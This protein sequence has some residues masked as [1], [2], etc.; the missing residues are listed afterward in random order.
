MVQPPVGYLHQDDLS[1]LTHSTWV[2]HRCPSV[3]SLGR[4]D[5]ASMAAEGLLKVFF[6]SFF[7]M[8]VCVCAC[9]YTHACTHIHICTH[10]HMHT[11]THIHTKEKPLAATGRAAPIL[12]SALVSGRYCSFHEVSESA[13]ILL[14]ISILIMCENKITSV[15]TCLFY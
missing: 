9:L 11:H 6:L 7:A 15:C 1:A 3:G 4:C 14:Q 13:I 5:C 12:V 10:T 8:A 2:A